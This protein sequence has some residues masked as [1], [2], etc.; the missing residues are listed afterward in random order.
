M[1]G[2][3]VNGVA[4]PDAAVGATPDPPAV[5]IGVSG[6]SVAQAGR[7]DINAA[8]TATR[9]IVRAVITSATPYDLSRPTQYGVEKAV[10]VAML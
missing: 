10:N 7:L 5:A 6:A 4:P 2:G 3:G 1:P 8:A 9:A